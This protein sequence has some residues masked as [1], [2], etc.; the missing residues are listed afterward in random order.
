MSSEL[1]QTPLYNAHVALKARMV[2]FAGWS[3]PVMYAGILDEVR[4][5]R[6]GV[7]LFDISHMG[8]IRVAGS[9]ATAL[10]QAVTSNDVSSLAF[11]QAQY[12]LL[13]NPDGG[14]IDDIIVYRQAENAYMVVI[15]ASNTEKDITWIKSKAGTDVTIIDD[16]A[17]TAMIAVQGP[18]AP[19]MTAAL[20]ANPELLTMQRFHYSTGT[21]AG[22]EATFCRTGYTGEDGFEV[23]VPAAQAEAVWNAL[24][25]AGGVPCGLGSRDAL[26]IEAGYPLYGHEIDDT[27]TPVG[28]LL[29]WAVSMEKG[30]FT[31]RD[32]IAAEKAAGPARKLMGLVSTERIQ[33]RQGYTDFIGA[34]EV[35]VVTSGVFSPTLGSSIA[36]AYI[37]S[38]YAKTGTAVEV[39][40]R[41]KRIPATLKQKKN[42]LQNS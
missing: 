8:R 2:D 41:D 36:M 37:D 17:A 13:T 14:I 9:G 35:G 42:L 32:N 28:A 31:G 4:A 5:V 39:S 38:R 29:M 25:A 34:E 22:A 18:G 6:T 20:A 10:L 15:N 16:S 24:V 19:A 7:G 27:T 33:P 26:R 23:I 21:I 1:L 30:D 12:S 40:V 11:S 3:M